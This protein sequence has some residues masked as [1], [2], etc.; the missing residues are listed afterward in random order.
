MKEWIKK[1][2]L[3]LIQAY[4]DNLSSKCYIGQSILHRLWVASRIH[5]HRRQISVKCL[6]DSF[7]KVG[8]R[9]IE[10]PRQTQVL[11][12][13]LQTLV[14]DIHGYNLLAFQLGKL[15]RSQPDWSGTDHQDLV[16][17]LDRC[18]AHCVV[19]NT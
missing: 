19:A 15:K 11:S 7:K 8:I 6:P 13:E 14:I 3:A 12:A 5:H 18:S 1:G 10:G 4:E 2:K 16:L 9:S 17:L